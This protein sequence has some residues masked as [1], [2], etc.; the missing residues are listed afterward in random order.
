MATPASSYTPV[1]PP[2]RPLGVAIL[3]VLLGLFGILLVLVGLLALVGSLALSFLS[4]GAAFFGLPLLVLG[5]IFLLF[6]VIVLVSAVGL[7]HLRLWA[8]VLA[9]IASFFELVQY[10]VSHSWVGFAIV[11]LIFVYLIAVHRHFH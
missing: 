3:A 6:G 5:V 11:F 4:P 10:G 1:L 9:L 2:S 7:W 8:L